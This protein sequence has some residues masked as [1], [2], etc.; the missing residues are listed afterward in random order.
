MADTSS[1]AKRKKSVQIIM[2]WSAAQGW[3]SLKSD[4][5]PQLSPS[6]W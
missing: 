3:P 4:C 1:Y 5:E 6:L 2:N